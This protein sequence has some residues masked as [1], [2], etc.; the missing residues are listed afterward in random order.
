MDP[1][2]S[3]DY[4]S[5]LDDLPDESALS[6]L[7][8][9]KLGPQKFVRNHSLKIDQMSSITIQMSHPVTIPNLPQMLSHRQI[10][11]KLKQITVHY[12]ALN[13]HQQGPSI[14]HSDNLVFPSVTFVQEPKRP[15]HPRKLVD[16]S[17]PT[18]PKN[19]VGRPRTSTA[20]YNARASKSN[21]CTS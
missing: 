15:G 19:P 2:D 18:A 9:L 7:S 3:P 16:P 11:V 14:G 13:P 10:S 8:P 17:V 12:S 21:S 1:P 6:Q 20:P 4:F 5:S